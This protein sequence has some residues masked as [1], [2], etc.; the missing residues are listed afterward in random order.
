[1]R[2]KLRAAVRPGVERV[3]PDVGREVARYKAAAGYRRALVSE[4]AFGLDNFRTFTFMDWWISRAFWNPEKSEYLELLGRYIT[5]ADQ[6]FFALPASDDVASPRGIFSGL[7][8]PAIGAT[9]VSMERPAHSLARFACSTPSSA[10]PD[11]DKTPAADLSDLGLPKDATTDPF[12]GK[13]L[14]VKKLP[15]RL[16]HLLRRPRSPRR[17]RPDRMGRAEQTENRHRP[18]TDRDKPETPEP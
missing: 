16:A 1:M 7:I 18:R 3:A 6:P 11:P 12:T 5:E 13:P 17:R 14:L 8:A 10:R 2:G 15:E 9:R 4:R